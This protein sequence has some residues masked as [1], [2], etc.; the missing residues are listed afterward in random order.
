MSRHYIISQSAD[1]CEEETKGRKEKRA[2]TGADGKLHG[3]GGWQK[4]QEQ[5]IYK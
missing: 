2:K 1:I 5:W 4:P 3:T